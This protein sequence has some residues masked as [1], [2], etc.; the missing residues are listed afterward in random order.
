MRWC[1]QPG[2]HADDENQLRRVSF[3]ARD[4]LS[5]HLDGLPPA[6]PIEIW[7]QDEARIG[8][9]N[10]LVRQWARRGTRPRQPAAQRYDS[11]YLVGAICPARGVGA[12]LALPFADTEAMQLH[13]E[14]ISAHVAEG[15]EFASAR[16]FSAFLGLTPRQN[17][18]GGKQR[19]GRIT[20]MGDR[21]LRKLLVVGACAT[22]RHR[23]GHNDALRLWASGMLERKTVKYKIQSDRGGARQQGRAHRLRADDEVRPL[24]RSAD[25]G[26][27]DEAIR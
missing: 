15:G 4:A 26:L 24:L 20:K 27:N 21:Y 16:E 23:K 8:Q 1:R 12:A 17:S 5:A 10:G 11:A 7:F 22:L 3:P 2:S 19:L 6:T 13:L 9:K 18:T 14:E 25:R